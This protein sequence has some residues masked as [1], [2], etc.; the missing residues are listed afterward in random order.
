ME[1]LQDI[2]SQRSF[3]PPDEMAVVKDYVQRRYKRT[4]KVRLERGALI[5]SVRGS[6]LAAT[7][8]LERNKLIEV[9]ALKQKLVIRSGG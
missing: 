9:C 3:A 4:C 1:S 2:M 8:Q 6:A 7:I 5:L